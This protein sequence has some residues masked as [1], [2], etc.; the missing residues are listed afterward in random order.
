MYIT[1]KS[2]EMD[3]N[4][5]DR[6]CYVRY[7]RSSV[8]NGWPKEVASRSAVI[9]EY[10]GQID[11]VVDVVLLRIE[12]KKLLENIGQRKRVRRTRAL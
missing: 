4:L 3:M 9:A 1:E 5:R 6:R 10:E 11:G 8:E 2:M 7:R 12:V